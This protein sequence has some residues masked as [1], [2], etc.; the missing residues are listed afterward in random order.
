MYTYF[1]E[2]LLKLIIIMISYILNIFLVSLAYLPC[3]IISLKICLKPKIQ[4]IFNM[5]FACFY[6]VRGVTGPPMAMFYIF[7]LESSAEEISFE[8]RK[9]ICIWWIMIRHLQGEAAKA[10]CKEVLKYIFN[11]SFSNY[12]TQFCV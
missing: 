11:L 12:F 7:L 8:N 10:D 2:F 9:S 5:S 3:W 6:L 4:T 1:S